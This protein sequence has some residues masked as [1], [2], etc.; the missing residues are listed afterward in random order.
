M[1][2]ERSEKAVST[3]ERRNPEAFFLFLTAGPSQTLCKAGTY[4]YMSAI[5]P[6]HAMQEQQHPS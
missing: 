4:I 3:C 2:N 1:T 6:P 5:S